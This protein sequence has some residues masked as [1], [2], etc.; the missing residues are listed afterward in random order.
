MNPLLVVTAAPVNPHFA[1]LGGEPAVARLVDA[2]YRAMSSRADAR[3]IRAMHPADLTATRQVLND[4]LCEWLGG[5]RR[6]SARRG[7]PKLRRAHRAFAIDAAARDAWM[8]CMRD[9]L[10]EVCA[11]AA[12]RGEL[13]HAFARIAE[14]IV[15]QSANPSRPS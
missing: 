1:R 15:N 8:A 14:H 10:G 13:E 12:L 7:P 5:P 2:F 6:Y 9:A 11:D 4:Y 3:T